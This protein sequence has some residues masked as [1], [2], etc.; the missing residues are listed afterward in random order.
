MGGAPTNDEVPVVFPGG[1]PWAG[2]AAVVLVLLLDTF[3]MTRPEP[4]R[5]LEADLPDPD[6]TPEGGVVRDRIQIAELALADDG[7]DRVFLLG[8]SR[9]R[10]GLMNWVLE[11]ELGEDVAVVKLAHAGLQPF[12]LRTLA[13]DC[14]AADPDVVVLA[15]SEYDT[16]RP[17]RLMDSTAGGSW[18]A[19]TGLAARVDPSLFWEERE[20]ALRLATQALLDS[21]RHRPVVHGGDT[22]ERLHFRRPDARPRWGAN[23]IHYH[24][25]ADGRPGDAQDDEARTLWGRPLGQLRLLDRRADTTFPDVSQPTRRVQVRQ[26]LS[27]A[28]GDH[29]SVQA[30]LIEDTVARLRGAG[31]EVLIVEMPLHPLGMHM[32]DT[33]LRDEF[34]ELCTRLASEHGAHVLTLEQSGPFTGEAFHDL[35]HLGGQ[36][37]VDMS[38]VVARAVRPLLRD[39]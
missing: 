6:I 29:A 34:L 3:A 8:T 16:H 18:A 32:Y 38:A 37:A 35:T 25:G 20:L 11:K 21:Y 30:G 33:A 17:L 24:V 9:A 27:I 5:R 19:L 13:E 2:L 4:W 10:R 22:F 23:E 26:V 31:V 39:G 1:V 14:L 36:G 7:R 15:L 12:E 28:A